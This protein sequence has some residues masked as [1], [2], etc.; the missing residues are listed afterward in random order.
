MSKLWVKFQEFK[1][2]KVSVEGCEDVNDV[3]KACKKELSPLLDSFASAQ[4]FLSTTVDGS[5]SFDPGDP[6]PATPNTSKTPL[7]IHII[8]QEMTETQGNFTA[9]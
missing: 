8:Q 6:I 9:I 3:I 5:S 2:V 4:L 7:Y 1:A